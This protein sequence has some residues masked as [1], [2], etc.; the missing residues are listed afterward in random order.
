M[1]EPFI[2]IVAVPPQ[3]CPGQ[4]ISEHHWNYPIFRQFYNSITQRRITYDCQDHTFRRVFALFRLI[5]LMRHYCII[6][7]K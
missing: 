6:R 3:R 2:R 1:K 4:N 7:Q 5:D